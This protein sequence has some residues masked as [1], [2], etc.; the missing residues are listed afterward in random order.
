MKHQ[1]LGM[2]KQ[3]L[4]GEWGH[5]LDLIKLLVAIAT[6]NVASTTLA[7]RQRK[8][9]CRKTTPHNFGKLGGHAKHAPYSLSFFDGQTV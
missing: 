9:K 6:T 7:T 4:W 5:E 1:Q 8:R 3:N 2:E